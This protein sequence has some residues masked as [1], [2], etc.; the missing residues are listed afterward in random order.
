MPPVR[1]GLVQYA[2]LFGDTEGNIKRVD[3]MIANVRPGTIDILLLPE[4]A[5]TGYMMDNLQEARGHAEMLAW[6][7]H[8]STVAWAYRTAK[9]LDCY[10]LVGMPEESS[11]WCECYNTLLI[12][13]PQVDPTVDPFVS[14]DVRR[15]C[16]QYTE[17]AGLRIS[18]TSISCLTPTKAGRWQGAHLRHTNSTCATVKSQSPSRLLSVWT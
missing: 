3:A 2:P 5:F 14:M 7:L 6:E 13:D 1:I 18:T 4:M 11:S 8:S 10:I 15:S 9:R 17:A 16:D 12:V